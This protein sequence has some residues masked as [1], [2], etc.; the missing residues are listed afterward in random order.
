MDQFY[1]LL[2]RRLT[3]SNNGE[4][5]S[6]LRQLDQ[7]ISK[8]ERNR[9]IRVHFSGNWF[10]STYRK[11]YFRFC[12]I[13]S[14]N[15]TRSWWSFLYIVASWS[16]YFI[17]IENKK[18]LLIEP[19]KSANIIILLS[20]KP[21]KRANIIILLSFKLIKSANNIILSLIYTN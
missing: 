6:K 13:F 19:I 9:F 12:H 16:S 17:S 18:S 21:I 15:S 2:Y 10:P 11:N 20:I 7:D 4:V 3:K 5:S 1:S 14:F 8:N